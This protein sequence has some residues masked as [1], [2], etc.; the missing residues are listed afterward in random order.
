MRGQTRRFRGLAVVA[1]LAVVGIVGFAAA[2]SA[3]NGVNH[4]SGTVSLRTT[5]LGKVLVNARG[6]TL[7]LFQKDK[8]ARSTCNGQCAVYWPPL[9]TKAKPTAGTGVKASLLGTTKRSDGT[10]QVTYNKHPLY[11]FVRDTAAG[12]VNGENLDEF[13]AEWYA[14]NAKGVKVEPGE[15]AAGASGGSSAPTPTY[16]DTSNIPGY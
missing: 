2:A 8:S 12:Q 16:T 5:K 3:T 10:M 9:T 7:Y 11:L 15:H 6:R 1:L 4:S 13:G 14:L